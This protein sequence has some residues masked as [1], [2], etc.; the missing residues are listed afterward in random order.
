MNGR[1]SYDKKAFR[2]LIT[3]LAISLLGFGFLLRLF[4]HFNGISSAYKITLDDLVRGEILYPDGT[5]ESFRGTTFP[6][7]H[8]GTRLNLTIDHPPAAGNVI[9]ADLCFFAANSC[10]EA[11]CGDTLIWRQDQGP[12][13]QGLMPCNQFYIIPLPDDYTEHPLTIRIE[14]ID[15]SSYT[16][17]S[18][19]I[20]PG[21]HA[22]KSL[23]AGKEAAFLLLITLSVV[24][25]FVTILISAICGMR[26]YV[27]PTLF[28]AWFCFFLVFWNIGSQGFLYILLDSFIASQGEYLALYLACIPLALYMAGTAKDKLMKTVFRGF[29][30]FF[31]VFF[32]Y[33]TVLN[34]SPMQASYNTTLLTLH[35]AIFLIIIAY[36]ISVFRDRHRHRTIPQAIADY[37]FRICIAIG[38]LEFIRFTVVNNFG[39]PFGFMRQSLGPAAIAELVISMIL[40]AGYSYAGELL[41]AAEKEQLR[42][43]AYQ[44]SLTGIPNRSACYLGLDDLQKNEVKDYTMLF[45]DLNFLKKANDCCSHE[46]G[47][48]MLMLTAEAMRKAFEKRGFYGRWGGDEFLACVIG[49]KQA[50]V[51]RK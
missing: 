6:A 43:L 24:S 5:S 9:G 3:V 41:E 32:L 33:V 37:G 29:A 14:S 28:L 25:G 39:A 45:L 49:G 20:S 30:A 10:V 36:F 8:K 48:K 51:S 16:N 23:L 26:K 13:E 42:K 21:G 35:T 18:M 46:I 31:V 50:G 27:N 7:V 38:L 47:D 1:L 12:I 40:S 19:W 15:R 2:H 17:I 4:L 44:D 11:S 34:F 22:I